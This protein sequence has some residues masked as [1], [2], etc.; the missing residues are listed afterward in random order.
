VNNVSLVGRLAGAPKPQSDTATPCC[1]A[2][3]CVEEMGKDGQTYKLWVPLEAWG[4]AAVTIGPLQEGATVA[5]SGKLKWRSWTDRE[6]TK[7]GA[8]VVTC[9]HVEVLSPCAVPE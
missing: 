5:A 3:L 9:W 1:S 7:Q 8:L 6:G 4:A 2:R